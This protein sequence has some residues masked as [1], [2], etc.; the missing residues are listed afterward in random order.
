[1]T[2]PTTRRIPNERTIGTGESSRTR[3]PAAVAEHAVAITGPPR[4]AASAAARAGDDPRARASAKRAC[5][6][7]A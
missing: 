4:A 2:I 5:S 3:N 6:W 1:M 7:I